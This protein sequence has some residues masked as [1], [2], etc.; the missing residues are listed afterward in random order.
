M[1]AT[2][3]AAARDARPPIWLVHAMNPVMR[4]MLRSPLGR[5]VRPLALLDFIGRRTG[6]RFLVPVGWQETDHGHVVVTPAPWRVNFRDG[7]DVTVWVRGRRQQFVGTLDDDPSHVAATLQSISDRN[8]SLRTVG[9]DVPAGH[10]ITTAD[11]LA[12][13]RAVIRFAHL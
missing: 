6:R 11:V 2:D 13:D 5:V 9:I 3:S 1:I 10:Q 12:V 8:G 7:S 4:L